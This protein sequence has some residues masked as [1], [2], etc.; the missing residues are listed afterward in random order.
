M[1]LVEQVHEQ[2]VGLVDDLGDPCVTAVDLVHDEHDRHV[3]VERLAQHEPGLRQRALGGVHEQDDPVDHREAALDLAAE[4]SVAGGVDDVDRHRH[5]GRL[6]DVADR[7]VLGEDR[8]PLLALQVA[9]V[10]RALV[11]V[12]VLTERAALPEHR[13]D[14]GGLA[15]VDVRD[16]RDVAEVGAGLLSHRCLRSVAALAVEGG[17][18]DRQVSGI[19]GMCVEDAVLSLS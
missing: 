6:A 3:G 17:H 13:V 12:L 1:R 16:D 7:G 14:E 8:D 11:D 5:L 2:L 18:A 10:H 9:G 15:V 19:R 4:V